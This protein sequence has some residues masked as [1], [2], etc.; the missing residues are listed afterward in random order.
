MLVAELEF[1]TVAVPVEAAEEVLLPELEV[2]D[3]LVLLVVVPLDEAELVEASELVE[4]TEEAEVVVEAED[5]DVTELEMVEALEEEAEEAVE[6]A[7]V[8][9]AET[10]APPTNWN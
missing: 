9:E 1:G 10:E 4:V 8:V 5:E 7:V 3:D 2:D 6:E